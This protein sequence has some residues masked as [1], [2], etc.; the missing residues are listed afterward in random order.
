MVE[1]VATLGLSL[2]SIS[3]TT[4]TKI[5]KK[6]TKKIS[7]NKNMINNTYMGNGIIEI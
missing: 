4:P 1:N 6:L 5:M 2:S 7:S 3:S